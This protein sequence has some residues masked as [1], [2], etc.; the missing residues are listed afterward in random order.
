MIIKIK[1]IVRPDQP[2]QTTD[3]AECHIDPGKALTKKYFRVA[4]TEGNFTECKVGNRG[5]DN[6]GW[7]SVEDLER[8]F[9]SEVQSGEQRKEE[10]WNK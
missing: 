9:I 7:L 5:E 10:L 4:I 2:D 1:P 8:G 3:Q 6:E